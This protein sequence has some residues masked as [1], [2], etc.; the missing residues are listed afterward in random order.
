MATKMVAAWSAVI[1]AV[2]KYTFIHSFVKAKTKEKK[3]AF[4]CDSAADPASRRQRFF[5]QPRWM[6]TGNRRSWTQIGYEWK[7]VTLNEFT[8]AVL[9]FGWKNPMKH[10]CNI[11]G[12]CRGRTVS[13]CSWTLSCPWHLYKPT[14]GNK[15]VETLCHIGVLKANFFPCLYDTTPSPF[16]MLDFLSL[17]FDSF[18]YNIEKGEGG[19]LSM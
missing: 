8:E 1:C 16:S 13:C 7:A 14:M 12:V 10:V 17:E 9:K 3:E 18:L 6:A 4:G 5:S 19:W 2:Y 11:A 15:S